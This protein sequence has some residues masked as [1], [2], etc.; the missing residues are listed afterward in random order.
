MATSPFLTQHRNSARDRASESQ[1][2]V[3]PDNGQKHRVGGGNL[4]AD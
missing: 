3:N 2:D 1:Q 4:D